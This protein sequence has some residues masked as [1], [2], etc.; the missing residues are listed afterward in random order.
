MRIKKLSL[1]AAVAVLGL[2]G[3]LTCENRVH[4]Q[5]S[6][7]NDLQL[8]GNYNIWG[9]SLTEGSTTYSGGGGSIT[10][11]Y[12]N[13]VQLPW[14]YCVDI[15]D[16]VGVPANYNNTTVTANGTVTVSSNNPGGG[17]SAGINGYVVGNSTAV[18]GKIAWI[19]DNYANAAIGNP[20]AEEAVQSAI[21]RVIYGTAFTVQDSGVNTAMNNILT[22]LGINTAALNSVFWLSPDGNGL[23]GAAGPGLEQALVTAAVPEPSTFA[24]A[25]LG[26]AGF[27]FYGLRRRKALGA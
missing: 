23:N 7:G 5:V 6:T 13:G 14:V 25:A 16:N 2:V 21:W 1:W 24:I 8:G 17:G 10:T 19:L 4:A 9:W 12:L 20:G 3:S 11:S 18:A 26:G 15:T 22:A 27:I